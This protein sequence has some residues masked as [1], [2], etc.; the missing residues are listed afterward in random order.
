M[1]R[2]AVHAVS[3]FAAARLACDSSVAAVLRCLPWRGLPPAGGRVARCGLVGVVLRWVGL[4]AW[5]GWA[6]LVGVVLRWVGLVAWPGWAGLGC[7][8]LR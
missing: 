5:P 8:V 2:R 3:A 1:L 6:E 4:V 7:V